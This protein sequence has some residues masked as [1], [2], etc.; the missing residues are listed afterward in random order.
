LLAGAPVALL[1][2]QRWP[3]RAL[4]LRPVLVV[5]DGSEGAAR[6][7]DAAARLAEAGRVQLT[8]LLLAEDSEAT[9]NLK[10]TVAHSLEGSSLKIR[11]QALALAKGHGL[12]Q[13]IQ[14]DDAALLVLSLS[15]PR[16]PEATLGKLLDHISNPVLLMR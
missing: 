8:I 12:L 2:V 10:L 15:S 3:A 7:L 11:W 13:V 1:L 4:G 6:A 16:L 5:Y 14:A 9:Q